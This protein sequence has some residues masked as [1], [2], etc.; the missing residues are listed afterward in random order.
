MDKPRQHMASLPTMTEKPP[1]ELARDAFRILATRRLAPTPENF[2]AIYHEITGSKPGIVPQKAFAAVFGGM[3]GMDRQVL[4]LMNQTLLDCDWG[5]FFESLRRALTQ[6]STMPALSMPLVP[7]VH[8]APKEAQPPSAIPVPLDEGPAPVH[9]LREQ[10]ARTIEFCLPALGEDDPRVQQEAEQLILAFRSPVEN[11]VSVG[12]KL[13]AFNHRLSFAAEDQNQIRQSLLAMLRLVFENIGELSLDDRWLHGQIEALM[14]ASEP[15]LNLRRLDDLQ[16]RLKDVIT[17]QSELKTR[18]MAA[19]EVMK[20]LLSSFLDR[21]SSMTDL[22]NEHHRKMEACARK[23]E[24]ATAIADIAPA[25]QEALATT[26]WLSLQAEQNRDE[27]SAM[28]R[29]ADDAA[30][31][32]E[33]LRKALDQAA[34]SARHDTLTGALNRKGLEEALQG[35]LARAARHSSTLAIG[36]LDIDNFKAINDVHGHVTGDEALTHLTRV[37]RDC[38]RPQDTLARYGGEEFVILM[39]DTSL[40]GAIQA[41]I[42]VQRELTRRFFMAGNS[43]LL[44]TFSAGVTELGAGEAPVAAIQRADQAMYQA[45]RAGKNKVVGV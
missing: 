9:H 7:A 28:K 18:T 31:E 32:T 33:Q 24:S 8:L 26:R 20:Q 5:R 23:I 17:K 14:L 6:A 44:I 10:L 41:M 40:E 30:A 13:S 27:L 39:P 2:A 15:P 34:A 3:E 21:L 22:S 4:Q 19:Q 36:F 45:K 25:M 12:A 43:R 42:R 38:M 1:P 37:A 16:R 29:K 11:V 35:E